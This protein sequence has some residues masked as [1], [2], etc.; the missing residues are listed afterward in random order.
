MI[1]SGVVSRRS[2]E[3][4][5]YIELRRDGNQPARLTVSEDG[6]SFTIEVAASDKSVTVGCTRIARDAWEEIV[7]RITM[8]KGRHASDLH[9]AAQKVEKQ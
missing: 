7:R 2:S 8:A 5:R 4:S 1:P 6:A 9:Q 3:R